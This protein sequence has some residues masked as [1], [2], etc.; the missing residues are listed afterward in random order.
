[1]KTGN[2]QS[3]A[4][5]TPPKSAMPQPSGAAQP[6]PQKPTGSL[7]YIVQKGANT[8]PTLTK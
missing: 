8:V 1:M 2:L 6:L 5:P 3:G 7:V 4:Q